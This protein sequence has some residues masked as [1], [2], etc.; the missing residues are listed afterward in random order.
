MPAAFVINLFAADETFIRVHFQ[1]PAISS[2]L[3]INKPQMLMKHAA[4]TGVLSFHH[5]KMKGGKL[6]IKGIII[7]VVAVIAVIVIIA[8]VVKKHRG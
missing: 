6:V 8:A 7:A 4:N 5:T 3:H 2:C 1:V